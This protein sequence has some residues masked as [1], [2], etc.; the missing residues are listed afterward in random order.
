MSV[1]EL[2]RTNKKNETKFYKETEINRI[3]GIE[4]NDAVTKEKV[5]D[6]TT[7]SIA[8]P[9]KG[10]KIDTNGSRRDSSTDKCYEILNPSL[11]SKDVLSSD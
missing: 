9:I 11:T 8:H 3:M 10:N 1:E 5:N 2:V 6:V 4:R 7:N